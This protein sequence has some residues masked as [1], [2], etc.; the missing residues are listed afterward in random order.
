M[1][2][3]EPTHFIWDDR[4]TEA[5]KRGKL[6]DKE[7]KRLRGKLAVCVRERCDPPGC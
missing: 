5:D 6:F 1:S 3:K 2:L 7:R 4:L